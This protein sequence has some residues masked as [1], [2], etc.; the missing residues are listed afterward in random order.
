MGA[1]ACA[2]L[3]AAREEFECGGRGAGEHSG[4]QTYSSG[5]TAARSWMEPIR[6]NRQL[7]PEPAAILVQSSPEAV[8]RSTATHKPNNA[9]RSSVY[10][11]S[12][13]LLRDLSGP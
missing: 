12:S 11:A 6:S 10:L 13:E 3:P 1:H 4:E 5:T 9:P 7:L 8:G 2:H